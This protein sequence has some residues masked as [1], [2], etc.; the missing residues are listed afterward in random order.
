MQP[1]QNRFGPQKTAE[2]ARRQ[3]FSFSYNNFSFCYNDADF[4]QRRNNFSLH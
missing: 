1:G 3:L 2:Q 4:K